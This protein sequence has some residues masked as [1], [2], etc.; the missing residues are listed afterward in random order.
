M[1]L[2]YLASQVLDGLLRRLGRARRA[3]G[4]IAVRRL[5]FRRAQSV[6][7]WFLYLLE[8]VDPY[9]WQETVWWLEMRRY[10][11]CFE[12]PTALPG[13]HF[14]FSSSIELV[15]VQFCLGRIR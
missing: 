9:R 6:I 12:H 4:A 14:G 3:S 10:S 13:P 8:L 2:L 5:F 15:G 11:L 1:Q 7:G